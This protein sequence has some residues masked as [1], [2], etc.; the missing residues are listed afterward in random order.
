MDTDG[1]RRPVVAPEVRDRLVIGNEAAG[2]PHELDIAPDL[3]FQAS[4]R[5]DEVQVAVDEELEQDTRVIAGPSR[6]RRC[7]ALE[8]E[9]PQVKVIDE[10]IDDPNRMNLT[11]PIPQAAQE[12]ATTDCDRSPQ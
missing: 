1:R 6:P 5:R 3:S 11:P 10:K 7:S 2:Q 8:P 4:A 9:V 12:T